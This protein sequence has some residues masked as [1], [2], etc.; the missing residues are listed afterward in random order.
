[1]VAQRVVAVGLDEGPGRRIVHIT[2]NEMDMGRQQSRFRAFFTD[3]CTQSSHSHSLSAAQYTRAVQRCSRRY[4]IVLYSTVQRRVDGS[5]SA[6][7]PL[8]V[9]YISRA[10]RGK[11]TVQKVVVRN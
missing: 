2:I 6:K 5:V 9:L 4:C 10:S 3:R 7:K 8:Y 11:C 1:M